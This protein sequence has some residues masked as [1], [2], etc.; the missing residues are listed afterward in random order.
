MVKYRKCL[1]GIP[2]NWHFVCSLDAAC[3]FT[4]SHIKVKMC[5]HR[6]ENISTF[7]HHF[8]ILSKLHEKCLQNR[9][10]YSLLSSSFLFLF[11]NSS[12]LFLHFLFFYFFDFYFSLS[13]FLSLIFISVSFDSQVLESLKRC[14]YFY[15]MKKMSGRC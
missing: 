15:S 14:T 11:L 5:L 3:W 4:S 12:S 10:H 6:L 13:L 2:W 8:K 7:F 9:S 1:S